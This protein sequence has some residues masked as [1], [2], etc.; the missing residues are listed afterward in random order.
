MTPDAPRPELDE[1]E[2]IAIALW[3]LHTPRVLTPPEPLDRALDGLIPRVRA[4]GAALAERDAEIARLRAARERA[5]VLADD[6]D[7][8][9]GED[10]PADNA[11][12]TDEA[13]RGYL[14][15][16]A[17]AYG[18]AARRLRLSMAIT[19]ATV[20]SEL[21][22]AALAAAHAPAEDEPCQCHRSRASIAPMHGGHCC[23]WPATQ[24]CHSREVA[25][26]E[27]R[28]TAAPAPAR[29]QADPADE[30]CSVCETGYRPGYCACPPAERE[31][32]GQR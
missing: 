30:A 1:A 9:A 2:R 7:K 17:N 14:A 12:V 11:R 23:F 5:L 20:N 29:E 10:G 8:E 32:G 18:E 16:V 21:G 25:D 22:V 26:W 19:A 27:R 28:R 24:T 13:S 3:M 6:L 31:G 15:G 4:L